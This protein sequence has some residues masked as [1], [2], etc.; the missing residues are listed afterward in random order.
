M[1]KGKK[2]IVLGATGNV[3]REILNVI[4]EFPDFTNSYIVACATR[5]SLGAK[6][7]C[8]QKVLKIV[9]LEDVNLQKGDIVLSAIGGS[10][11]AKLADGITSTGAILVD[12]SSYFRTNPDIPLII[13]EINPEE[14]SKVK[15]KN[16]I[17]NP[18]CSTIQVLMALYSLHNSF[19]IKRIIASTY[20]AVSGA[21]K[22]MMDTLFNQTKK[23]FEGAPDI[24]PN[25][26]KQIAFNC[27]PKIGDWTE[28]GYTQEEMKMTMETKKIM[29][30]ESIGVSATC[31][32]VPVFN[33]HA[34][35][36][37][38]EF[39]K[40]F[41]IE[42]V[43]QILYDTNG[44]IYNDN[45]YG[46]NFKTQSECSQTD[47]VF[48]SRLRQDLSNEKA[49]NMWI[50]ADNLRKGAALNAVQIAKLLLDKGF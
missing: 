18:N 23:M 1:C 48:I 30:D 2:I 41:T 49:L 17:A 39:N 34:V 32:R 13:P 47:A 11:I 45:R 16:I 50:V 43:E 8:G 25:T 46:D 20:Q 12:N 15:N 14:I 4:S 27:V 42:N 10:N 6:V 26:E 22:A 31:V 9:S 36:I 3:G 33:C 37:N 7:S 44:I 38:V 40:P 19:K 21:G 29:N 5:F 35:S 28:E 24:T